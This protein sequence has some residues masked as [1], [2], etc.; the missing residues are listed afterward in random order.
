MS[1]FSASLEEF[2]RKV[3]TNEI[4]RDLEAG[5]RL[6]E[7]RVDVHVTLKERIPYFSKRIDACLFGHAADATPFAVIVE[8]RGWMDAYRQD[9]DNVTTLLG[10]ADHLEPHPSAQARGC[11]QHLLD[12]RR[13]RLLR[14]LP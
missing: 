10:G 6:A 1:V 13:P 4:F 12:S 8:L 3:M 11:H 9:D 14:V 7:L 5:F 2:Q